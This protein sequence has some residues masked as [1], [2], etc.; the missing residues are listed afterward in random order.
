MLVTSATLRFIVS[1]TRRRASPLKLHPRERQIME[2]LYRRGWASASDIHNELPDPPTYSTVRGMLVKLE[3]KGHVRHR[4]DG[5]RYL[6]ASA[7][8]PRKARLSAA[9]HFLD[10]LFE[11]SLADAMVALFGAS[12]RK[13]SAEEIERIT[14]LI[15]ARRRHE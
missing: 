3:R 5:K 2:V 14:K 6:Y 9:V 1:S 13:L 15:E 4:R 12:R 10:S 7:V 11:G 8:E